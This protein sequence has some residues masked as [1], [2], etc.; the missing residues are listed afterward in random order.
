M[1]PYFYNGKMEESIMPD[2]ILRKCKACPQPIEIDMNNINNV[3]F[4]KTSY[5]HKTCFCDLATKRAESK[6]GKY[7]DWQCALDNLLELETDAKDRLE[8]PFIKDSFNEYLLKNY[9][10]VAVPDRLWEVAATLEKGMYKRKKC[11]PVSIKILYE[12]WQWGQHKLNKINSQNKMNNKG[13]TNDEERILY[14]LAILVRKIPNYLAH[15][16]KLEV[17][18][19]EVKNEPQINRINYDNLPKAKV[20]VGY[21]DDISS[22]LD[23]M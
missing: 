10:V 14:D 15:K 20:E 6:K 7:V 21:F 17:L 5:Y 2:V 13:P 8:Y 23:E 16:S 1:P 4:Y 19:A 11:K 12:A 9:N 22:L 18:Q 3:I